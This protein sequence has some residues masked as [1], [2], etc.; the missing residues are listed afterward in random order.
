MNVYSSP[1]ADL[2]WEE[3][4]KRLLFLWRFSA[5]RLNEED[6]QAEFKRLLSFV[7]QY[8]AKSIVVDGKFYPYFGNFDLQGWIDFEFLRLASNAGITRV[9]MV[10]SVNEIDVLRKERLFESGELKQ[11]YFQ[12]VDA[13]IKWAD[14]SH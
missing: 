6:V 8:G 12:D 4:Y 14:T 3:Q 2:L 10:A 9:A 7:K 13:A 5:K 1:N 11:E